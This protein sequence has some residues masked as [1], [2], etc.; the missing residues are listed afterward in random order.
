MLQLWS[1]EKRN[2]KLYQLSG[3]VTDSNSYEQRAV[4]KMVLILLGARADVNAKHT[5]D[6][7]RCC[8][9]YKH[10]I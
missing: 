7:W 6:A 2:A 10:A 1:Q 4:E 8:L 5:V 3:T 9:A